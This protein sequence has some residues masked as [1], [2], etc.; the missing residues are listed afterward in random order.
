VLQKEVKRRPLALRRGL[1]LQRLGLQELGLSMAMLQPSQPLL[2][3]RRKLQ[4]LRQPPP[5]CLGL[6]G[7]CSLRLGG[8]SLAPHLILPPFAGRRGPVM[9][10]CCVLLVG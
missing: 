2:M 5:S 9:M 4:M 3:P 1:E 6:P 10:T 8:R 7:Q